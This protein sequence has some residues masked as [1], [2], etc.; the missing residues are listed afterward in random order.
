MSRLFWLLYFILIASC[1]EAGTLKNLNDLKSPYTLPTLNYSLDDLNEVIDKETMKTHYE[2]HHQAY[3]NNLNNAL[4]K[5]NDKN[6][7]ES[8]QSILSKI[9]SYETAVR[10]NGGGHW[11]HSFFWTVLSAK[12][13]DK[14]MPKELREEIEHNFQSVEN[15]KAEFEK[16]GSGLFGSGW[17]WL[18]RN[19]DGKLEITATINQDNPLMDVVATKGIPLLALDV[20]E[21]A[22]YL[23]YKNK[24]AEYIKN[25]WKIINWKQVEIYRL[26]SKKA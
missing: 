6:N 25:F 12:A 23:R 9:S 2:K 26:E 24:R 15:F 14:N 19:T 5:N 1:S 4:D 13:E 22:Y 16:M 17:V 3:I 10:N 18:I 21:H 7:K 8:L 11:N 20:W